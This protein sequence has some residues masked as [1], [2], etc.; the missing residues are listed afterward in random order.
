MLLS[1]TTC[2]YLLRLDPRSSGNGL[3]LGCYEKVRLPFT[4]LWLGRN[5]I[6]FK[7]LCSKLGYD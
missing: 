7:G 5:N 3:P 6:E 1:T 4:P 2:T